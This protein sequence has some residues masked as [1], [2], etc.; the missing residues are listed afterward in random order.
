MIVRAVLSSISNVFIQNLVIFNYLIKNSCGFFVWIR[1]KF[2]KPIINIEN[3]QIKIQV[4]LVNKK[5]IILKLQNQIKSYIAV[6]FNLSC[7]LLAHEAI[8]IGF[9]DSQGL[10]VGTISFYQTQDAGIDS[11]H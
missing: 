3:N 4:L 5:I 6:H 10:N 2:E 1:I 8:I 11:Y 7:Y 9:L